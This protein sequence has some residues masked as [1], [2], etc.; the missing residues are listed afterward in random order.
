M[1]S[2]RRPLTDLENQYRENLNRIWKDKKTA[3]KTEAP[4]LKVVNLSDYE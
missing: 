1:K 2:V 3:L 4:V